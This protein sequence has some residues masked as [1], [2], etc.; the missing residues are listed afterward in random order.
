LLD[1]CLEGRQRSIPELVEVCAQ[2]ADPVRVEPVDAAVARAAVD[3]QPGVLQNLEVLRD[4]GPADG[5]VAGQL[6]NRTRAVGKPL[7]DRPPRRV[8]KCRQSIATS[9]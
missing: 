8:A 1:G 5:Q 9:P 7:E 2:S 6:A 4:G 3:H